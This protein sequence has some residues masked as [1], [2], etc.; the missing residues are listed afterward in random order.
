MIR[1][2]KRAFVEED[3]DVS[4][5]E[6]NSAEVAAACAMFYNLTGEI[7]DDDQTG[8]D[9]P[10]LQRVHHISQPELDEAVGG[11]VKYKFGD[12]WRWARVGASADVSPLMSATLAVAA[13]EQAEWIGGAYDLADSLG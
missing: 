8:T 5:F 3:I 6:M 10:T 11:A 13:G 12:R 1:P 7:S 9:A 2:L 4:L